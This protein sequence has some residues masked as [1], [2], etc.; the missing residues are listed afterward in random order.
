MFIW[1]AGF[2][3]PTIALAGI[4]GAITSMFYFFCI[5]LHILDI[6]P[7]FPHSPLSSPVGTLPPLQISRSEPSHISEVLPE[8]V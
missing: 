5:Q 4:S 1:V 7:F 2:S 6:P 3:L 8:V